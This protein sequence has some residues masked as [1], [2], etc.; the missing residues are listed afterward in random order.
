MQSCIILRGFHRHQAVLN[1]SIN[2]TVYAVP[3]IETIWQV[4]GY[5]LTIYYQNFTMHD[6][7][8]VSQETYSR[9][10]W[11]MQQY[12]AQSYQF[13]RSQG[14]TSSLM[15][16]TLYAAPYG[17]HPG[18]TSCYCS[19]QVMKLEPAQHSQCIL[20]FTTYRRVY[21][22]SGVGVF[23]VTCRFLFASVTEN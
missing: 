1:Q 10:L 22:V 19:L 18:G 2:T 9:A 16:Y 20:P 14:W 23:H 5:A 17:V 8:T 13:L 15:H 12:V 21:T 7:W 11:S 6:L 4:S 3:N